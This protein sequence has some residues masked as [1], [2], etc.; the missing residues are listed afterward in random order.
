MVPQAKK[1]RIEAMVSPKDVENIY[2]TGRVQVVFVVDPQ[3]MLPAISGQ[4][5]RLT[6]E[7]SIIDGKSQEFV[8]LEIE[9]PIDEIV[10]VPDSVDSNHA[11]PGESF[12]TVPRGQKIVLGQII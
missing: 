6:C 12:V 4:V 10:L 2:P 7:E 1:V 3:Q 8:K 9:V 5:T 11:N